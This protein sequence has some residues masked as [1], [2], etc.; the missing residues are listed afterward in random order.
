MPGAQILLYEAYRQ[1]QAGAQVSNQGGDA[2]SHSAL[3][4][5]RSA[6]VDVPLVPR[7]VNVQN[8]VVFNVN[9][10]PSPTRPDR[11][12]ATQAKIHLHQVEVGDVDRVV[13]IEVG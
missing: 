7:F 9:A 8:Y 10:S 6:Q 2:H 5:Y 1:P 13:P 12:S 4:D 11:R 3:P